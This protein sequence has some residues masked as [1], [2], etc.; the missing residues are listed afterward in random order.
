MSNEKV[1]VS[2]ANALGLNKVVYRYVTTTD[3]HDDTKLM[4]EAIAELIK[5]ENSKGNQFKIDGFG[6]TGDATESV[7]PQ[8]KLLSLIRSEIGKLYESEE[9]KQHIWSLQNLEEDTE[10]KKEIKDKITKL[11][12]PVIKS[13]IETYYQSL[14]PQAQEISELV[15]GEF[16]WVNGNH[17]IP[18]AVKNNL[19][20]YLTLLDE[21]EPINVTCKNGS[22]LTIGG[23]SNTYE[24][25]IGGDIKSGLKRTFQNTGIYDLILQSYIQIEEEN[26]NYFLNPLLGYSK[27]KITAE[28]EQYKSMKNGFETDLSRLT[29]DIVNSNPNYY[30]PQ[31]EQ[32]EKN[33]KEINKE[34][35]K[36]KKYLQEIINL[37]VSERERLGSLKEID[38]MLS[39]KGTKYVGLNRNGEKSHYGSNEILCDYAPNIN[40]EELKSMQDPTRSKSFGVVH[41]GHIHTP[42]PY[43]NGKT[44]DELLETSTTQTEIEGE[45][46]TVIEVERIE[47]IMLGQGHTAITNYDT[48]GEIVSLEIY[49]LNKE[50]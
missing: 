20:N 23:M 31:K 4:F 45:M 21:Q 3:T 34:L 15:N 26:E 32:L 50:N 24:A 47:E 44:L 43:I 19:A 36:R 13:C 9:L 30:Q 33:L 14:V 25:L 1:V 11:Q 39:H 8:G 35:E 7:N 6:F 2:N 16:H 41:C 22:T 28:I 48:Q 40:E 18:G 38:I 27:Q 12:T 49:E 29:D 5:S 46:I 42:I 37:N 17:D 10:K